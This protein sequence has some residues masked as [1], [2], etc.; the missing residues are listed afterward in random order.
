MYCEVT[1]RQ[2]LHGLA[3]AASM[4]AISSWAERNSAGNTAWAEKMGEPGPYSEGALPSG[5][6]SRFV[7][8]IN[9]LRLHVI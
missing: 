9:G 1:R 5:L 4:A 6:R 8:G 7:H 3:G 2:L